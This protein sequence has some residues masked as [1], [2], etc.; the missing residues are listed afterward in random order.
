MKVSI[1]NHE[2]HTTIAQAKRHHLRQHVPQNAS[3]DRTSQ[4]I[5]LH[6]E[7][8][9]EAYEH[10]YG[11]AL[12]QYNAKQKLKH[13]ERCM[14]TEQ[15]L[16]KIIDEEKSG[17]A[18]AR[19][20]FYGTVIQIGDKSE[21]L[22]DPAKLKQI[23][24]AWHERNKSHIHVISAVI[25]MD[26]ATPHIHILYIPM[27]TDTRGL[28]VKNSI[29]KA[30]EQLLNKYHIELPTKNRFINPYLYWQEHETR[31]IEQQCKDMGLSIEISKQITPDQERLQAI[32]DGT[33][34]P[35]QY[36]SI[37]KYRAEKE[38]EEAARKVEKAKK[39]IE[40]VRDY[41][42]SSERDSRDMGEL[43]R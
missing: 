2:R 36:K 6:D 1:S 41:D 34:N 27:A 26:E 10:A 28:S 19:H 5:V 12:S 14:T 21:G 4:N 38:I 31:I 9:L 18:G 17:K 13:P 16:Q 24:E 32:Q 7:E 3:P 11:E 23:Y 30:L 37:R 22:Q 20:P 42:E 15:Y 25:H 29:S 33:Y 40:L 8:L 39:L 43:T 35:K